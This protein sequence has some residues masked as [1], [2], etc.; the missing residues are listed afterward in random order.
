MISE[1]LLS[2]FGKEIFN[3]LPIGILLY[4]DKGEF[5]YYNDSFK[6][7]FDFSNNRITNLENLVKKFKIKEKFDPSEDLILNDEYQITS[8]N[9]DVQIMQF[10]T[11]K[12]KN[13]GKQYFVLSV[14]NITDRIQENKIFQ[15]F[16]SHMFKSQKL[17]ALSRLSNS[18]SHDF[19]N[20]MTGI[21]GY[22][23][24]LEDELKSENISTFEIK[25]IISHTQKSIDLINNL[26][27]FADESKSPEKET[28]NINKEITRLSQI[29]RKLTREDIEIGYKLTSQTLEISTNKSQ[30]EEILIQLIMNAN[31]A[32][33]DKG[34]ITIKTSL[35]KNFMID[36]LSNSFHLGETFIENQ[37]VIIVDIIDTGTGIPSDKLELIFEPFFT[38]KENIRGS[39]LGLPIVYNY[40]KSNNSL[41]AID[42]KLNGGTCFK[43]IFPA[44][45][46]LKKAQESNISS[47]ASQTQKKIIV[48]EDDVNLRGLINLFFTRMGQIVYQ[49]EDGFHAFKIFEEELNDVDLL[50]TDVIMPRM[51]G[52]E[53]AGSIYEK[54]NN[55]RC[56]FVTGHFDGVISFDELKIPKK[57]YVIVKKP[58]TLKSL[59]ESFEMLT[60]T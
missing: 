29:F 20:L 12:I 43:L 34:K 33:S 9:N 7:I 3:S 18:L 48:A 46:T 24:F 5:I 31:D 55:L 4:N 36:K 25:E 39:G 1:D 45:Q 6:K 16:M 59:V 42:T 30:F 38:T 44:T 58:F 28:I 49:A 2:D 23:E 51:G 35:K 57:Q 13:S 53:L 41:I 54:N 47:K 40:M 50:I 11:N 10:T 60:S 17:E 56:I 52:I 26:K 32:I 14:S 27:N 37:D 22:A 19:N 15:N 21:L 8:Q